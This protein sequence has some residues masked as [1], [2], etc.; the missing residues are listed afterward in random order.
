MYRFADN[1]RTLIQRANDT[2]RKRGQAYIDTGDLLLALLAD[3]G[4]IACRVLRACDL[5]SGAIVRDLQK[6]AP[7]QSNPP[8]A[9]RLPQEAG[10]KRVIE[11]SIEEARIL[12]DN[13]V[14]TEHL[15]LGLLRQREGVA[16]KVLL[17]RGLIVEGVREEVLKARR[18]APV[19]GQRELQTWRAW[20][21]QRLQR[22]FQSRRTKP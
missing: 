1:A 3:Q 22:L 20:V 5:D 8:P 21:L 4:D 18:V 9:G 16:A 17:D 11:Y 10:V 12:N 13:Q 15:L 14:G 19:D 6:L 2:A 7:T